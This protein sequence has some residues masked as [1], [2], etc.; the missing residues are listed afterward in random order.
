MP[1]TREE[2]SVDR[3]AAVALVLAKVAAG[4]SFSRAVIKV[5]KSGLI[6][7]NGQRIKPSR[8]T[9]QRWVK[10]HQEG[11][12][13]ALEPKSRAT[14]R[15]SWVLT[16]DFLR[17]LVNVKTLDVDASI[18]EVIR[19][20][21]QHGIDTSKI[22]RVSVWRAARRLNL[23]IFSKKGIEEEDMHRF[24]YPHRMQ[25]VLCDGKYFRAGVT[26]RKR[27][28]ITFLDDCSR[29]ALGAV[30]GPSESADLFLA[31][32]FL[33][34]RRWGKM[35]TLYLDRGSGFIARAVA[36][37]CARL[38][39]GLVHGTAGYAPGRG[40]IE[41]YHR[42][43]N[44]DLLR[45]YRANPAIDPAFGALTLRVEHYLKNIY[46]RSE[47]DGLGKD[48]TPEGRFLSDGLPLR[49]YDDLDFVRRQFVVTRRRKVAKDNIVMVKSVPYE[50]PRGHAGKTV[51][52][53]RHVLDGTI[54]IVHEGR[55]VELSKVDLVL[56]AMSPRAKRRPKPEVA[57]RPMPTAATMAFEKDHQPLVGEAGDFFD[58]E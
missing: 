46:N 22:R 33:V 18:P 44:K 4:E 42:T 58:K 30:V 36:L 8:R 9:L 35:S 31:G 2:T 43:L 32:L 14:D 23:P 48:M 54:S 7:L 41:R 5:A 10:T 27:V 40:K 47:H 25:M 24:A 39:I 26:G 21:E 51:D 20:A 12:L 50:V 1:P 11:G 57:P 6:G 17:H 49:P 56:N 28:V 3:Y 13:K 38:N 52:V 15:P 53:F 19:Q 34:L 55:L 37:I 45:S 29:F 16:D